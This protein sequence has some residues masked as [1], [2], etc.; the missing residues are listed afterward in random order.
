MK[1]LASSMSPPP[2]STI[3]GTLLKLVMLLIV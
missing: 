3:Y 1:A 2:V